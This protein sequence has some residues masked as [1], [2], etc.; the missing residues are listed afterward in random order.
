MHFAKLGVAKAAVK[1]VVRTWAPTLL[2]LGIIPLI[3]HPIDHSVHVAMD[4]TVRP[5]LRFL[6]A[7]T[8]HE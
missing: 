3:V 5:L 7:E 4:A 2:G 6:V 8:N 1:P